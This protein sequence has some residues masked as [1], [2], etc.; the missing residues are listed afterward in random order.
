MQLEISISNGMAGPFIRTLTIAAIVL[1]V[2]GPARS[3][4]KILSVVDAATFQAHT[5][6]GGALATLFFSQDPAFAPI[7]AP[8]TYTAT[9]GAPLPQQLAGLQ[10]IVNG[11][12]APILS[13]F[14]PGPGQSTPGQINF[15]VPVERNATYNPGTSQDA[16]TLVLET[17]AGNISR[18]I[19]YRNPDVPG[20]WFADPNGYVI[21]EHASDYSPV[22]L[23]NPAHA[24]ENIIAY[25]N[26]F[27]TVWPPPPIA[28]PV[29]PQP[30]FQTP[31]LPDNTIQNGAV[32]LYLQAYPAIIL[33]GFGPT[34]SGSFTSTPA[35][36]VLF[37]GLAP[38][39][40]GVEQINF[41]VPAD[42][43]PG[44]WALFFNVGSCPDGSG[45]CGKVG[46]STSYAK[47]PVR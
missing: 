17:P 39:M 24:G 11:G 19:I 27:F 46:N 7:G 25:G 5:P 29:P 2:P 28:I 9:S 22:T 47:L 13:V 45:P 4:I 32:H 31:S 37:E 16:G 43:G 3:Q 38:G 40:I 21:A 18:G 15:Q 14:I 34:P 26:D 36:P 42:Q 1:A 6:L 23:Q 33:P 8:G 44:D 10:V 35:I 30:L 20:G 12:T 41:T